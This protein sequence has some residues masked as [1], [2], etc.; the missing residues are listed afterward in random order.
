M[1]SIKKNSLDNLELASENLKNC[2]CNQ[3]VPSDCEK[4]RILFE[5]AKLDCKKEKEINTTEGR[6]RMRAAIMLGKKKAKGGPCKTMY[7]KIYAS[8]NREIIKI[9]YSHVDENYL[10]YT[11]K[12]TNIDPTFRFFIYF[13]SIIF[14]DVNHLFFLDMEGETCFKNFIKDDDFFTIITRKQFEQIRSYINLNIRFKNP[15]IKIHVSTNIE[16]LK[17]ESDELWAKKDKK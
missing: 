10:I 4:E 9:G 8:L 12:C 1:E 2:E 13:E 15:N 3:V 6:L 11:D 7:S 16:K 17:S 14:E 5:I